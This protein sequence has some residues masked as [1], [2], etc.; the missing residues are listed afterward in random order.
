MFG[1]TP[2]GAS[3]RG[4]SMSP[5]SQSWPPETIEECTPTG[6]GVTC[7]Y[8][9]LDKV[10]YSAVDTKVPIVAARVKYDHYAD[11]IYPLS[12]DFSIEM[13]KTSSVHFTG[14][15]LPRVRDGLVEYETYTLVLSSSRIWNYY[16]GSFV[17][18]RSGPGVYVVGFYGD[19]AI[20][21][22]RG[23]MIM[24]TPFGCTPLNHTGRT[25]DV[26]LVRP[27]ED[28]LKRGVIILFEDMDPTPLDDDGYSRI[29]NFIS[30]RQG[31]YAHYEELRSLHYTS[32]RE[33]G[34]MP[35]LPIGVPLPMPMVNLASSMWILPRDVVPADGQALKLIG[36]PQRWSLHPGNKFLN[37]FFFG[38]VDVSDVFT[39][40]PSTPLPMPIAEIYPVAPMRSEHKLE[41]VIH[42]RAHLRHE[43]RDLYDIY[44]RYY[45][46]IAKFEY[47]GSYYPIPSVYIDII[48]V[49]EPKG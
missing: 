12:L 31:E 9:V 48:P 39:L 3:T 25:E 6:F 36:A 24:C 29:F 2:D 44:V 28:M 13:T 1:W 21:T 33:I 5:R 35:E 22:Y 10:H 4:A 7:I 45:Y 42:V 30:S 19:V 27:S 37:L 17:P 38:T 46:T 41:V 14:S 8:W 32:V 23:Y 18:P 34:G 49:A 47:D 43:Y 15:A 40:T 26:Y 20:A 16:L 11:V